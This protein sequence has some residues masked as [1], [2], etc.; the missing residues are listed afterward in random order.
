[1]LESTPEQLSVGQIFHDRYEIVRRLKAGGMGAVYECIHLKTCKHRA[2]KVMLPQIISQA[3]M[4]DRFELEARVTA[5]IESDHIVETFDAGID[6]ETGVLFLVMELLHGEDLASVLKRRGGLPAE[7]TVLLLS[8]AALALDKTHAAGIVHRDLK[9]ANLYVTT[10][11]DGSLRLK[12]LDFGIAKVVADDGEAVQQTAMLGTPLYM[13]QEQILGEGTIGPRADLYAL[14]HIAFALL[15]GKA[16]WSDEQRA[17]PALYAFLEKVM[18]G[19][20]EPATAR[21][22]RRGVVLPAAF[23]AWFARATARK[24]S[25]RFDRASTLVH[26]LA[27][28]MVL[29][30]SARPAGSLQRG[31]SAALQTS[32]STPDANPVSGPT[33]PLLEGTTLVVS[34]KSI[35]PIFGRSR[36]DRVVVSLAALGSVGIVLFIARQR[37]FELP[38]PHPFAIP[39]TA[40]VAGDAKPVATAARDP[41]Q[42][43]TPALV[44]TPPATP[45]PV[46]ATADAAPESPRSRAVVKVPAK[47]PAS[48]RSPDGANDC[49]P[50]F[51]VGTNG[52]HIIKPWCL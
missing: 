48:V 52:E 10:R 42:G 5:G 31:S 19:A 45:L 6:D 11:D 37:L 32:Q 21:A 17:F 20:T 51:T 33:S 39:T 16:Y 46:V 38:G 40:A 18:A 24:P 30:A 8:Q 47:P 36:R 4:R 9:P 29:S 28:V 27:A 15:T 44:A 34:S 1:M 22:A 26:E 7:E 14:G 35:A 50:H 12:I 23:D 49:T 2:L 3:G 43:T 25:D 41:G 13:S